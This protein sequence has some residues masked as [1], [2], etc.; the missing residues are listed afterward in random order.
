MKKISKS[1]RRKIII[2]N[3]VEK[4][5]EDSDNLLR[6]TKSK[7]PKGANSPFENRNGYFKS[8]AYYLILKQ[9][10]LPNGKN[11][12]IYRLKD[13][14]IDVI[15]PFNNRLFYWGLKSIDPNGVFLGDKNLD[16]FA[17][18]M[19]YAYEHGVPPQ[20]LIGFLYQSG[21]AQRIAS[22]MRSGTKEVDFSNIKSR[23]EK[24]GLEQDRAHRAWER[25]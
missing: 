9:L 4:F 7:K 15:H 18:Q 13:E 10:S 12:I 6:I 19:H 23:W 8:E 17:N 2:N 21:S 11:I 5:I 16:R 3:F 1:Q 22:K 14:G 25:L 20:H 24:L